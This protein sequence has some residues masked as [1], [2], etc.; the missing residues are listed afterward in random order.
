MA[1]PKLLNRRITF[2]TQATAQDAFGENQQ[3]W[4]AAYQCWASIAIQAS[5]LYYET[6]EFISNKTVRITI[7]WNP[8]FI[9]TP[10]MRVQYV[11]GATGITH[12]YE[13]KTVDNTNASNVEVVILAYELGASA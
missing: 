9:V 10:A 6:S 13:V 2:Q 7:R 8:A 5:Q 3:T 11:E 4:T 12:T 1:T